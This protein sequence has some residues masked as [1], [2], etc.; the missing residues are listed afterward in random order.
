MLDRVLRSLFQ[1]FCM[2][3]QIEI[4]DNISFAREANTRRIW[5]SGCWAA[6]FQILKDRYTTL[7][8][9]FTGWYATKQNIFIDFDV[10]GGVKMVLS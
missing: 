8:V 4:L 1:G 2:E 9:I 7:L 6:L 3:T 5:N 10:T